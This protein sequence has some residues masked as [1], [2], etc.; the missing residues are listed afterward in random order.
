MPYSFENRIVLGD[1]TRTLESSETSQVIHNSGTETVTLCSD[2]S[3]TGSFDKADWLM[4]RGTGFPSSDA[5]FEAGKL[6]RH[7]L[8]VAFAKA[9][10]SADFDAAPVQSEED[11]RERSDE[12]RGL[13][14]YLQPPEEVRV[15]FG[16]RAVVRRT[17]LLDAFL[18]EDLSAAR[19]LIP[20]GLNRQLKLAY[21]TFHMALAATNPEIKYI[22]FVTAIEVL[23]PDK[24]PEKDSEHDKELV[25]ALKKLQRE[26]ARSD[27]RNTKIR[28]QISSVLANAQ[29]K[30]ITELGKELARKL[31][32]KK[33]DGG[34]AENFFGESYATRSR[35][36]HGSIA[37]KRPEPTE[38]ARR[39]PCLKEFVLDLLTREAEMLPE[40]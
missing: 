9:K 34:S 38:I 19:N 29:K 3:Q 1:K 4:L 8:L 33:Y 22:L 20:S 39:L 17:R 12:A 21:E 13:R 31:D 7:Q 23:I 37:E 25:A 28:G 10:I 35:I 26:V 24:K 15:A 5:A 36:V 30:S 16:A 6:W 40:S 14:V 2:F 18:S 11:D 27:C 32:P